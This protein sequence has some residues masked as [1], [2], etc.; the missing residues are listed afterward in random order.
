ME[1]NSNFATGT[2][3]KFS[4]QHF[5]FEVTIARCHVLCLLE[6]KALF[7]LSLQFAL[8]TVSS[9]LRKIQTFIIRKTEFTSVLLGV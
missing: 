8:Q 5:L 6:F 2:D 1:T 4:F 3:N 9:T 7:K